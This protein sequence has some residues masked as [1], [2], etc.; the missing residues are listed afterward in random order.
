MAMRMGKS[1]GFQPYHI[2]PR[3]N[4]AWPFRASSLILMEKVRIRGGKTFTPEF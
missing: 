1:L 2:N 3:T 4:H